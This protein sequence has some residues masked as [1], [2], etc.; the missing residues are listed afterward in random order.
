[1]HISDVLSL[2]TD[3][4]AKAQRGQYEQYRGH[5]N[6]K[7]QNCDLNQVSMGSESYA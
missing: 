6:T 1:M 3:G 4:E 2:F 5:M 7:W